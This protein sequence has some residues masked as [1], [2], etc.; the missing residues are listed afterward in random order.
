VREAV[1]GREQ[2]PRQVEAKAL[3]AGVR[4]DAPRGQLFEARFDWQIG[5]IGEREYALI[6]G[7]GFVLLD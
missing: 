2:F 1:C 3:A 5:Q 6:A 4:R 7:G